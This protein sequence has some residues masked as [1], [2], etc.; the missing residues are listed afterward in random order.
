MIRFVGFQ[1]WHCQRCGK[2]TRGSRGSKCAHCGAA[3]GYLT[4]S[5]A[6]DRVNFATLITLAHKG[7]V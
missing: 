5:H 2:H 3:T 6:F 1:L 4:G 7:F